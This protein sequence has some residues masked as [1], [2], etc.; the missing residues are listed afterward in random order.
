MKAIIV[1]DEAPIRTALQISLRKF[2]PFVHII[3]EAETCQQA[4]ELLQY[5]PPDLVFLDIEMPDETGFDFL[6]RF[7]QPPFEVIF[8]T[9]FDHYAIKAIKFSAIDYLLKPINRLELIKAVGKVQSR[10]QN[11]AANHNSFLIQNILRPNHQENQIAIPKI[12]GYEFIPVQQIIHCEADRENT[13]IH[14]EQQKSIY[15][16]KGL[17][18]LYSLLEDY[19]FYRIHKSHIINLHKME[20]YFKGEGGYVL[21]KNQ[22][23]IDISRRRKQGFLDKLKVMRML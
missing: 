15:A 23:S 14:L 9:G 3:G 21:M 19:G 17:K 7:D 8:I 16:T 2:C 20:R 1:D 13:I 22:S 18:E 4:F 12:N 6:T 5:E 10:L 11:K